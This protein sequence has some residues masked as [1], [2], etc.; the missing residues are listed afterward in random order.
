MKSIK[1]HTYSKCKNG[2]YKK[3]EKRYFMRSQWELNYACYLD[4]L[5]QNGDIKDWEY[6]VDTFWFE[7]IKRGVRSY[8]PDFKIHENNGDIVYHEVKGYMDAKSKTKIKRMAKYHPEIKLIV[9][10]KKEYEAIKKNRHL[11]KGWQ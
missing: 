7:A 5:K 9:I 11:F 6:E 8:N 3:G 2:W 10:A 4:F 1:G